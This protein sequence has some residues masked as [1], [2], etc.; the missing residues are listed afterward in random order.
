MHTTV[1]ALL[2]QIAVPFGAVPHLLPHEPQFVGS[3]RGSTHA[4]LHAMSG[5][6]HVGMH[7]P[8]LHACPAGHATPH[9]PQ[10]AS[11]PWRFT[12]VPLHG[13]SDD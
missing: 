5:A 13:V 4:P 10:L 9:L 1:Q 6:L 2:A 8:P 3:K 12:H 11:S 7:E